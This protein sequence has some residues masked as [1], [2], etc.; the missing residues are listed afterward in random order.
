M[1]VPWRIPLPVLARAAREDY[2]TY[3]PALGITE[4]GELMGESGWLSVDDC[5]V[6]DLITVTDSETSIAD[7][8]WA[9]QVLDDILIYSAAALQP[10]MA[11][12]LGRKVLQSELARALSDGPGVLVFSGAF[13][14]TDLVDGV[15]GVFDDIIDEQ[16]G[17]GTSTDPGVVAE[18]DRIKGALAK[19]ADRA[20][21][22]FVDYYANDVIALAFHAWLGPSY[23][24]SS[25]VKV[26]NPGAREDGARR[27]HHLGEQTIDVA[28]S[29][30]AHVHALSP[31]LTLK[32]VVAHTDM[33]VESGPTFFLPHSQKYLP[34]YVAWQL[35]EFREHA[36]LHHA[37]IPLFKGDA[38]FFNP[39]V[40]HAA[41]ENSTRTMRRMANA[42]EGSSR[43][44]R[45]LESIDRHRLALDV[46]DA[47]LAT[48]QSARRV[49]NVID[50][51][52]GDD[53]HADLLRRA[54]S[55]RWTTEQLAQRLAML[56]A[57]SAP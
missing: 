56:A 28:E 32:G 14:D 23:E 39:A 41:G 33:P 45:S 13:A 35:P 11:D 29:Y 6:A 7:Y 22:L 9:A 4:A 17:R 55:E 40:F 38:V 8:P 53:V 36:A 10:T 34:G 27:V 44:G 51:I 42:I 20:P 52:A 46:Y 2:A 5:S 54:L 50:A 16:R 31:G 30:P 3:D 57:L 15:S 49:E 25:H 47:L 21:E 19:L 12:P 18:S 24:L 43:F 1:L 48:S 37:Q 26:V